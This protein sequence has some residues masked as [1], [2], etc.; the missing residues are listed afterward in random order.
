M[1]LQQRLAI[2]YI[3]TKF[4]VL[5]AFS[6]RKAAEKAFDLFCTPYLKV[7]RKGHPP[8][9]E[10]IRF[11][12]EPGK[13]R[14][15]LNI[16]GYRWNHPSHHRILLL[17]GFGS[18]AFKFE[19]YVTG[20]THKGYEVLAIDAPAHGKS[21]GKRTN[22]VEYKA[23]ILEAIRL[24]G[25]FSG[26]L[27][28]SFGG[29]ALCLALEDIA[30]HANAKVVLI[31]PATETTSAIDGAFRRLKVRDESVR[32]EF[33][34]IIVEHSGKPAEWYSIRRA[35]RNIPA[36]TLWIHDEEDDITPF[37]DA[38][39]VKEDQHPHI[40]FFITKGLGH[41]KIYRDET[42]KKKVIDFL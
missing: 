26:Y 28:H 7:K 38:M 10:T 40:E 35:I 25:P 9:A 3:Q 17:H 21:D 36:R 20:L 2:G 29:I 8:Q 14:A 31:A 18:A 22:A 24:F 42:V 12:L 4:K 1:K 41:Q 11:K 15:A 32:K 37:E 39:K 34:R 23:M 27:A 19:H 13:G 6:S 5:T 16:H 30:E 33:D